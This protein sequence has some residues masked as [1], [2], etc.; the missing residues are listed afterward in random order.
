MPAGRGLERVLLPS[1]PIAGRRDGPRPDSQAIV[2]QRRRLTLD[3]D[4]EDPAVQGFRGALAGLGCLDERKRAG[5]L[6]LVVAS[7]R[8]ALCHKDNVPCYPFIAA[9]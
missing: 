6:W 4:D 2:K 8:G 9:L 5:W 7:S 1:N 3:I